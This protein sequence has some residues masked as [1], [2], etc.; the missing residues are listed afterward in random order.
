V[1]ILVVDDFS[2]WRR[3]ISSLLKQNP[4]WHVVSEASD[5]LEAVQRAQELKPDVILLDIGLPKLNGIEAARRIREVAPNSKILFVS[6]HLDSDF[7]EAALATGA[8]GY[9]LK[10]DAGSELVQAVEAALQGKRFVSRRLKGIVPVEANETPAPAV[11][12]GSDV[13]ASSAAA[14]PRRMDITHRHEVQFY[15]DDESRVRGFMHFIAAAL[16]AGNSAI[17]L[18]TESHRNALFTS[19]RMQGLDIAAAIEQG[20][21]ISVDNGEILGSFMVGGLP[22]RDRFLG[23]IGDLVTSAATHA[24]GP[25]PH[26]VLCGECAPLL[27]ARGEGEAA[28]RLEQL[29]SEAAEVHDVAI[30]CGYRSKR[31]YS[32][33]DNDIFRRVCAQHS[34]VHT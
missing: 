7:V 9:V 30:L 27:W 5:G 8:C 4:R 32:E 26:V 19:L 33:E 15:A 11:L 16:K 17:V 22:D 21:Y 31:F 25:H 29:A 20:R 10:A 23:V 13:L 12:A 34:V 3:F 1:R 24:R 2:P 28:V 6:T 18:A 14:L